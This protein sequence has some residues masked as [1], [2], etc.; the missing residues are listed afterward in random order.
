MSEIIQNKN[1]IKFNWENIIILP[2]FINSL[3]METLRSVSLIAKLIRYKYKSSLFECIRF[4]GDKFENYFNNNQDSE[5]NLLYGYFEFDRCLD[6]GIEDEFD[7]K[8]YKELELEPALKMFE[9]QLND[10]RLYAKTVVISDACNAGY[11][12][13]PTLTSFQNL[14]TL[15]LINCTL[16][17]IELS[18]LSKTLDNL[19]TLEL[20]IST[21]LRNTKQKVKLNSLKFGAKVKSISVIDCQLA[22]SKL[23]QDPQEFLF[24]TKSNSNI[25]DFVLPAVAVPS[26]KYYSYRTIGRSDKLTNKFLAKNPQLEYLSFESSF[27]DQSKLDHIK[28]TEKLR[29]LSITCQSHPPPNLFLI[30]KLE[31]LNTLKFTSP[32]PLNYL[33]IED[34]LIKAQNLKELYFTLVV[35]GSTDDSSP[36]VQR[37]IDSVIPNLKLEKLYIS[38]VGTLKRNLNLNNLTN[39]ESL[40]IEGNFKSLIEVKFMQSIGFK[41]TELNYGRSGVGDES[42]SFDD[43]KERLESEVD[44]SFTYKSGKILGNRV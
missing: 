21:L 24:N 25:Q 16:P 10:I 29:K 43:T 20:T 22:S 30:P 13:F 38:I 4:N 11:Y 26:L 41:Q 39:I 23:L 36:T 44:W 32:N 1:L 3:P 15:R 18:N 42:V 5:K 17:L 34:L 9:S 7:L 35:V 8:P 28:S 6:R 19:E 40:F 37:L 2:D 14:K 12:L 27:L 31:A 33:I